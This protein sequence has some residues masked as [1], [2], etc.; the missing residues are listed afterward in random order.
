MTNEVDKYYVQNQFEYLKNMLHQMEDLNRK[1]TDNMNRLNNMMLE[2]KGLTAMIRPQVKKTGWY[3]KEINSEEITSIP[4][5]DAQLE[6]APNFVNLQNLLKN[7][8]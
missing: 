7:E 1:C 8:D 5:I 4:C 2:M 3:G 6:N